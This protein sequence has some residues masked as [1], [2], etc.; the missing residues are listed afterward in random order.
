MNGRI[1]VVSY[2]EKSKA[3]IQTILKDMFLSELSFVSSGTEARRIINQSKFDVAIINS[4]LKDENGI[5]ISIHLMQNYDIPTI[6]LCKNENAD[7]VSHNAQKYGVIV[8]KKPFEK[9][10]L[11]NSVRIALGF[12]QKLFNMQK[13]FALQEKKLN[14]TK[15]IYHAKCLLIEKEKLSENEAHKYIEKIAMD[16]RESK[17]NIASIIAKKYI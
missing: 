17:A 14:D 10:Q 13:K 8:L 4:P 9:E 7:I 15:I 5:D 2:S 11:L 3:L 12:S 16:R 1:L 6:L